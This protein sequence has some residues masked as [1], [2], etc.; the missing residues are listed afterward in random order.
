MCGRRRLRAVPLFRGN[1]PPRRDAGAISLG[2]FSNR[3]DFSCLR[4][5]IPRAQGEGRGEGNV[6]SGNEIPPKL[7]GTAD[8]ADLTSLGTAA[9]VVAFLTES[10]LDRESIVPA[11][12]GVPRL[13]FRRTVKPVAIRSACVRASFISG[14]EH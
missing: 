13:R 14:I 12:S 9:I 6:A 2:G 4:R 8:Q 10:K 11:A 3:R 7:V 1:A 5:S